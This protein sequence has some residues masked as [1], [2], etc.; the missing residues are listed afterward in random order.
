MYLDRCRPISSNLILSIIP[1]CLTKSANVPFHLIF[2][3]CE[4]G[5]EGV[6]G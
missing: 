1:F 3:I 2:D 4:G 5:L 6:E